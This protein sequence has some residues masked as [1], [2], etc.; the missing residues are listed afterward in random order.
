MREHYA[1]PGRQPG[2]SIIELLTVIS[3]L[4]IVAALAA[5]SFSEAIVRN[6]IVSANNDFLTG[7]S[8]ARSEAIKRS[9]PVGICALDAALSGCG[10]GAWS[11]GWAVFE[12][13]DS[14]GGFN[15]G[16]EVVRIA[17]LDSADQMIGNASTIIFNA[18]GARIV[19]GIAAANPTLTLQPTTC[20]SGVAN[21]RT[22]TVRA[23]GSASS[24]T[25]NCP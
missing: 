14:S 18:R 23:T 17:R 9:N 25:S 12:D 2:Y 5:P 20:D 21:V 19:P 11:L 4:G 22:L 6:R 16:D 8:Y 15:A 24:T 1:L 7:V 10:A 13:T 3:I